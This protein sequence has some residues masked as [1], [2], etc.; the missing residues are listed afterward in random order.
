MASLEAPV[1]IYPPTSSSNTKLEPFNAKLNV[2]LPKAPFFL[3]VVGPRNSGKTNWVRNVLSKEPGMYGQVFKREN[4]IL[5]K[6]T[7]HDDHS[8]DE[9]KLEHSFGPETDLTWLIAELYRLIEIERENDNDL[10][11][12]LVLDDMTLDKNAWKILLP[13]GVLGR[14]KGIQV[15][16]ICHKLSSI[17]RPVRTQCQQF[18]LFR[19]HEQS[20]W[21]WVL[22]SFASL[23]T[24]DIWV[25]ALNRAWD[26][27]ENRFNFVY[28]DFEREPGD[29]YHS[30]F[31]APLFTPEEE[32]LMQSSLTRTYHKHQQE[33]LQREK[34][35]TS[36]N[37][38]EAIAKL[39]VK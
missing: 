35:A 18:V 14:H 27:G 22:K 8:L 11:V 34:I 10:P 31:N 1:I 26:C 3:S 25:T 33:I 15:M 28:I 23:G 5:W 17:I 2:H 7:I 24:R 6:P 38:A 13:L 30:G 32:I 19:P 29:V 20:E 39:Q 9:L 37:P 21:E 16:F 12:L 4:I 36:A